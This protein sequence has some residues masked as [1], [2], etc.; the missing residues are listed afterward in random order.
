MS[1]EEKKVSAPPEIG[2]YVFPIIL[3]ALGLWCFYDG[4][5]TTDPEMLEHKLFNQVCSVILLSWAVIDFIRTRRAE[6]KHKE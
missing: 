5:I 3:A 2:P 1:D 6:K 4:W